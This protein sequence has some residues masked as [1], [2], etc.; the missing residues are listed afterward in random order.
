MKDNS[1]GIGKLKLKERDRKSKM[2]ALIL[3]HC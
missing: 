3:F 2:R 1:T